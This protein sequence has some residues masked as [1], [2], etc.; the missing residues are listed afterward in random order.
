MAYSSSNPHSF[1][2]STQSPHSESLET[3]L[4]DLSLLYTT[5]PSS[6]TQGVAGYS[7]SHNHQTLEE[8]EQE[9]T[10][11]LV[12]KIWLVKPYN[13]MGIREAIFKSWSFVKGLEISYGLEDS[14][15]FSF[16]SV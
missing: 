13:K 4:E 15:I 16:P 5:N 1:H 11:L 10:T 7:F 12:S 3:I 2:N 14:L 9:A 6:P 8:A